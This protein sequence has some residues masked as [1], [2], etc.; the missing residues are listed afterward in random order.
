MPVRVAKSVCLCCLEMVSVWISFTLR[1]VLG[2]DTLLLDSRWS[3]SRSSNHGGKARQWRVFQKTLWDPFWTLLEAAK[4]GCVVIFAPRIVQVSCLWGTT[5]YFLVVGNLRDE[6]FWALAL[7][8]VEMSIQYWIIWVPPTAE[9]GSDNS[10]CLASVKLRVWLPGPWGTG[11]CI[12]QTGSVGPGG[13]QGRALVLTCLWAVCHGAGV[14]Q[15]PPSSS[16]ELLLQTTLT[17]KSIWQ[18]CDLVL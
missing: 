7:K 2:K 8:K 14:T 12:L 18:G 1:I 5:R 15:S 6:V 3:A 16:A 10:S 11:V 17:C 13:N 4:C 9:E